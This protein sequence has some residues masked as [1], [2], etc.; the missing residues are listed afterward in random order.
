MGIETV[1][2]LILAL[3]FF[4]TII[5]MAKSTNDKL[6]LTSKDESKLSE[7]GVN[8]PETA[9][10]IKEVLSKKP[11]VRRKPV[12]KTEEPMCGEI[13]ETAVKPVRKRAKKQ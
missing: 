7:E 12:K 1:V 6:D 9:D 4:G 8:A 2:I 10:T 11:R 5:I 3:I 13:V